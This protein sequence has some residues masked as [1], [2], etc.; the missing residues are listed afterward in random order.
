MLTLAAEYPKMVLK[1]EE[2]VLW[3]K[4]RKGF[5]HHNLSE[6]QWDKLHDKIIK[7]L[8]DQEKLIVI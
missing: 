7:K 2:D 4:V 5:A 8:F 1:E 6:E 3:A